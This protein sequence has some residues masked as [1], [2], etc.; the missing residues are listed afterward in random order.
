MRR[1]VVVAASGLI[2]V[3]L[4]IGKYIVTEIRG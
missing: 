4:E 2:E 1:L 3:L